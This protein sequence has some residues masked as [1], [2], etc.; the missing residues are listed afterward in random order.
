MVIVDLG[1]LK[2]RFNGT[3][4]FEETIHRIGGVRRFC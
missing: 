2:F 4:C 1:F 3:Q